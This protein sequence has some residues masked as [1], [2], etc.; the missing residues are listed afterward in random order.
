MH[1]G[2]LRVLRIENMNAP[3][4]ED[5]AEILAAIPDATT[6]NN[7]LHMMLFIIPHWLMLDHFQ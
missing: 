5:V 4:P 7:Q 2:R 6:F 1:A 3:R